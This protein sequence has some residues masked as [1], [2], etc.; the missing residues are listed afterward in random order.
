MESQFQSYWCYDSYVGESYNNKSLCNDLYIDTLEQ[1]G[2]HQANLSPCGDESLI[3]F[4]DFVTLPYGMTY[5][6]L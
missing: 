4:N 1:L 2:L 5:L 6:L 3:A